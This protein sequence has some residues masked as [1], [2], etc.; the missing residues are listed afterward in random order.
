V[1][2][3]TAGGAVVV[4]GTA[5]GAVVVVGTAGGAGVATAGVVPFIVIYTK[6]ANTARAR[7]IRILDNIILYNIY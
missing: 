1:V 4:V 5:G 2:V 6:Y 3:G 7:T